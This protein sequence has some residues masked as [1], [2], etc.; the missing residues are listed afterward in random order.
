MKYSLRSLMI[1]V[2][3]GPPILTFVFVVSRNPEAAAT[4]ILVTVM[5]SVVASLTWFFASRP[6]LFVRVFVPEEE[7]RGAIRNCVRNPSFEP[8]MRTMS[9]LQFA[10]ALWV[11]AALALGLWLNIIVFP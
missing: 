3:V 9:K 1:V 5:F 11:G 10:V 7:L 4:G 8:S 2:L 6:R